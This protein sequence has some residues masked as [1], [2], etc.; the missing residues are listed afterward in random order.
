MEGLDGM[1]GLIP[2]VVGAGV[3]MKITDSMLGSQSKAPQ[4]KQK[5]KKMKINKNSISKAA[6]KQHA[7]LKAAAKP[8]KVG[9]GNSDPASSSIFKTV[10]KSMKG[11]KLTY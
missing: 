11:K 6:G 7:Q 1:T 4:P 2:M 5:G 3:V 9:K 10:K 8:V